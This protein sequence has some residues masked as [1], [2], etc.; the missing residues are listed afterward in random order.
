MAARLKRRLRRAPYGPRSDYLAC[1]TD[2]LTFALDARVEPRRGLDDCLS[3]RRPDATLC[4]PRIWDEDGQ[5]VR[6]ALSGQ[7]VVLEVKNHQ[8]P[9]G[10]ASVQELLEQLTHWPPNTADLLIAPN[11]VT[12]SAE[13]SLGQLRAVGCLVYSSNDARLTALV[14]ARATGSDDEAAGPALSWSGASWA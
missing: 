13:R 8:R 10:E 5:G 1:V 3:V 2:A 14:D 4:I 9:A 12:P 6:S 11:G 7:P